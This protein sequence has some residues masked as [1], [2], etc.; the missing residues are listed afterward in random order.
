MLNNNLQMLPF[1]S[2]SEEKKN[3]P[4]CQCDFDVTLP[5]MTVPR[6]F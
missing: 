6:F 5:P 3:V 2:A 4:S 1:Y